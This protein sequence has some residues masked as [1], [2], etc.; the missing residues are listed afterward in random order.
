MSRQIPEWFPATE[1][2]NSET[3]RRIADAVSSSQ[4]TLQVKSAPML[5]YWFMLDSLHLAN[6]ANWVDVTGSN[7]V[8]PLRPVLGIALDPSVPSVD[9]P[10]GYAAVG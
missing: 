7:A 2:A 8:L 5:A 9:V 6:Q 10:V 3:M 4:M 1:E